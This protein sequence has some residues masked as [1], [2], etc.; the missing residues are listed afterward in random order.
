MP[1]SEKRRRAV[2]A[3]IEMF[4]GLGLPVCDDE[5]AIT[6]RRDEQRSARN[7]ELNSTKGT[8]A[9]KAQQWF[10]SADALLNRRDELLL[11]VYEEFTSLA[12]AVLKS[13]LEAGRNVVG[14]DTQLALRDLA[15][16]WCRARADLAHRWLGDFLEQRGL[17][18]G[19]LIDNAR[20]VED[21]RAR[22]RSG[23]VI[24]TWKLPA[25]G[26]D[27]VR[28]VR[29]PDPPTGEETDVYQGNL[30]RFV[31]TS[32]EPRTH[33]VYRAYSVLAGR[34][35]LLSA[36]AGTR[37]EHAGGSSLRMQLAA[38]LIV[39]VSFGIVGRDHITALFET[40][41][42]SASLTE[43][44]AEPATAGDAWVDTLDA[45]D[46]SAAPR[47]SGSTRRAAPAGD[48]LAKALEAPLPSVADAEAVVSDESGD[49][50]AED[51]A[52]PEPEPAVVRLDGP[53]LQVRQ[54]QPPS[55]AFAEGTL[56]VVLAANRPLAE[57]LVEMQVEGLSLKR[58]EF[59]LS[60]P[61]VVFDV[62]PLPLDEESVFARWSF[63][64]MAPDGSLSEPV[65]G[66]CVVLPR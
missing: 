17:A 62:L 16:S 44:D 46:A 50:S 45:H 42:A 18:A 6:E 56:R 25:D 26:C 23:K 22:P 19:G 60:P 24:V 36:T 37:H 13:T 52:A 33:Y 15:M 57:Q 7:R 63:R 8:V 4:A 1:P 27:E 32:V 51:V 49:A 9:A 21:L 20:M 64:L 39:A 14:T 43:S 66:Q 35:S 48:P 47:G 31:D 11:V 59:D 38:V 5:K 12:D 3:I 65:D 53:P 55:L 30:R 61:A 54:V 28:L 41:G 10:D 40:R 29:A 34:T 58:L 2:L